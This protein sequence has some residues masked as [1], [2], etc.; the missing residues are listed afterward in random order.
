M[1]A[2]GQ[3]GLIKSKGFGGLTLSVRLPSYAGD[4][5]GGLNSARRHLKAIG[6]LI[7]SRS[8]TL[9]ACVFNF[10]WGTHVKAM[11]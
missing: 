10:A 11:Y 5:V 3:K 7:K 1:T 8:P 2:A 4:A 9:F 6:K